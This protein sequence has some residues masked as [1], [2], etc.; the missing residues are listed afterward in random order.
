MYDLTARR[1]IA[2]NV[3]RLMDRADGSPVTEQDL[4]RMAR[5]AGHTLSQ[6]TINRILNARVSCGVDHLEILASLFG[7][8]P[9]QLLVPELDPHDPP[10][11]ASISKRLEE[12]QGALK[13]Q[14]QEIA[15]LRQQL[16]GRR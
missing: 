16:R 12:F 13:Q 5:R 1:V 4:A 3:R 7:L 10:V 6:S 14:A 11:L 9:W 15:T 2:A 8:E